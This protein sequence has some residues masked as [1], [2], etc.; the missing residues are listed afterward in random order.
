MALT[1]TPFENN[2]D[3]IKNILSILKPKQKI[4]VE[5]ASITILN[6]SLRKFTL[7]RIKKDVLKDLPKKY[8]NIQYLNFSNSSKNEYVKILKNISLLPNNQ[9]IGKFQNLLRICIENKFDRCLE[10]TDHYI[11]KKLKSGDF[12]ISG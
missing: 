2:L 8:K 10:I 9:K 4:L 3:D 6:S 11:E 7:R 12:L 1:G 5:G